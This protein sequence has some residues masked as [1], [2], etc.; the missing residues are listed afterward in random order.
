MRVWASLLVFA[1]ALPAA[2]DRHAWRDRAVV[3]TARFWVETNAFEES[4]RSLGSALEAVRPLFEDRFGPLPAG[5]RE[6]MRVLL[7][8]TREEYAQIGGGIEGALGHFDSAEDACSLAWR[9]DEGDAGWPIAVHEAC[10]HYLWR[11]HGRVAL[12]SWYGEGIA[13]WFEGASDEAGVSRLRAHTARA[14][15]EAGELELERLLLTPSEVRAGRIQVRGYTPARYY[16]IAWSLVHFLATDP[17]TRAGF[18]RF[19]LR[20][21]A[22][23]APAHEILARARDLLEEECGDVAD[24]ERRWRE[25]VGALADPVPPPPPPVYPFELASESAHARFLALSRV[26]RTGV[27]PDLREETV[28]RLVDPDVIVRTAAVD[29]IAGAMGP[30]AVPA[31]VA[32]LDAGDRA[33]K[34]AAL[35]ALAHPCASAAVPRLLVESDDRDAALSALA[36]IGDARAHAA[37][38]AAVSDA[39]LSPATRS[40][41]AAA[42]P[43]VAGV[44]PDTS[45]DEEASVREAAREALLRLGASCDA[46]G[47]ISEPLALAREIDVFLRARPARAGA[48]PEAG[49]PLAIG[50][51]SEPR[52][53]DGVKWAACRLLGLAGSR[54]AVPALRRLC[55]YDRPDALRLEAVR[56][57]VRITG[58]TRGFSPGQQARAREAAYR[59]WAE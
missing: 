29:A 21:F 30:D 39:R 54:A 45:S 52:A 7:F 16:A 19:E 10:H 51:L 26:R 47:P 6:P 59:A 55:R 15:L 28:A 22:Q 43:P 41:C 24:L 34:T 33:L 31:L 53:P 4:A 18:R 13:C 1:A 57:L 14:A 2:P 20:L 50:A 48:Q 9:G 44:L 40:A 17:G 27:S 11:R 36:S 25:H 37:L 5:R 42:L 32:A 38:R 46:P 3:R 58:E 56:A 35:R 23:R 8:R 49:E 12:P